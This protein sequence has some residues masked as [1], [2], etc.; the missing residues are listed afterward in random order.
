MLGFGLSEAGGEGELSVSY[1]EL[2][3]IGIAHLI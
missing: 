1:S 2:V 3:R